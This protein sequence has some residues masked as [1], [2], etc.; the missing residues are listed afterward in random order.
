MVLW[1]QTQTRQRAAIPAREFT[2]PQGPGSATRIPLLKGAVI[3]AL[4]WHAG[5]SFDAIAV[6][7]H[8]NS[9]TARRIVERAKVRA[10]FY[11]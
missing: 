4:N 2:M 6:E 10:L 7:V 5:L 3:L 1:L 11:A 9:R 8:V